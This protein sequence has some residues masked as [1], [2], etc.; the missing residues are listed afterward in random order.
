MSLS[1]FDLLDFN[2]SAS[3]STSNGDA[4]SAMSA[5]ESPPTHQP[6]ASPTG[7]SAFA[8]RPLKNGDYGATGGVN[9]DA[10]DE[11][12]AVGDTGP[13]FSNDKGSGL[14][15]DCVG[16]DQPSAMDDVEDPGL[17]G[18]QGLLSMP[19]VKALL[20]LFWVAQVSGTPTVLQNA[21]RK[22]YSQRS[23]CLGRGSS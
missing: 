9:D 23:A 13:L 21:R 15:G 12:L 19:K 18:P 6:N 14:D 20:F 11:D 7:T 2:A 16:G 1:P 8:S 17:F 5:E 22:W 4:T 3:S 10:E